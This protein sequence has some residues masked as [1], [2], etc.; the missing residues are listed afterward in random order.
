MLVSRVLRKQKLE[1]NKILCYGDPDPQ[2]DAPIE[3]RDTITSFL[4]NY[5]ANIASNPLEDRFNRC[6]K[7]CLSN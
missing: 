1:N 7:N 3:E 4:D 5:A 6:I 2:I